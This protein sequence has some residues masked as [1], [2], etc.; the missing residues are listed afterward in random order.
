[1]RSHGLA[2]VGDHTAT[3]SPS[4]P[5]G[6]TSQQTVTPADVHDEAA[7]KE[8]YIKNAKRHDEIYADFERFLFKF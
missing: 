7:L 4:D 1:M 2:K 5:S 8:A 3:L 6:H